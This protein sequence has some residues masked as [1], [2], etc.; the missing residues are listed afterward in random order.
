MESARKF[1]FYDLIIHLFDARNLRSIHVRDTYG[2]MQVEYIGELIKYF[3]QIV[4]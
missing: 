2:E 1:E 3:L 4:G